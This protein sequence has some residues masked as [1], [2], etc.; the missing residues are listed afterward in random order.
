M[1]ANSTRIYMMVSYLVDDN[2]DMISEPVPICATKSSKVAE[3]MVQGHL[4]HRNATASPAWDKEI[5]RV[6]PGLLKEELSPELE[7]IANPT[8][9]SLVDEILE[10]A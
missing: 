1:S 7:R 3:S 8:K 9:K 10:G 2:D 5:R 4:K 6:L